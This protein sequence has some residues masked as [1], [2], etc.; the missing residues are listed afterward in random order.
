MSVG[1]RDAYER[2]QWKNKGEKLARDGFVFVPARV[3]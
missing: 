3:F 2:A 1:G